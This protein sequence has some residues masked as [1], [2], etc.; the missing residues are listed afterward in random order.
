MLLKKGADVNAQGGVYGNALQAAS[1]EGKQEISVAMLLERGAD[2]NAQ[3][4]V[5]GNALQAASAA[6]EK[7]IV[8]MLLEKGADVDHPQR[9]TV[10]NRQLST[11]HHLAKVIVL[12]ITTFFVELWKQLFEKLSPK[13]N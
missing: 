11:A 6:G 5:A 8:A 9:R 1:A 10:L 13:N 7:E 3:G 12:I 2:V 4:G